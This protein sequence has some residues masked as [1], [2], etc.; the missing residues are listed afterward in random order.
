MENR[1]IYEN[2]LGKPD[3]ER[4]VISPDVQKESDALLRGAREQVASRDALKKQLDLEPAKKEAIFSKIAEALKAPR[5]IPI[6]KAAIVVAEYNSIVEE[7]E[8]FVKENVADPAFAGMDPTTLGHTFASES[9]FVLKK[10]V[11]DGLKPDGSMALTP[12]ETATQYLISYENGLITVDIG[13]RKVSGSTSEAAAKVAPSASAKVKAAAAAAG[14]KVIDKV[15][16]PDEAVTKAPE[17]KEVEE[18]ALKLMKSGGLAGLFVNFFVKI[19]PRGEDSTAGPD[20][21]KKQYAA[22]KFEVYKNVVKGEG[23]MEQLAHYVCGFLGAGFAKDKVDGMIGELGEDSSI[24]RILVDL[25][26]KVGKVGGKVAKVT[27]AGKEKAEQVAGGTLVANVFKSLGWGGTKKLDV[28]T[29]LKADEVPEEAVEMKIPSNGSVQF[30]KGVEVYKADG[31]LAMIDS[32]EKVEGGKDGVT[33]I[34]KPH[35]NLAKGSVFSKGVEFR[36]V[37]E[38]KE[39]ATV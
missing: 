20:E 9:I 26:S 1:L 30:K 22:R 33:L 28:A 2:P 11:G 34:L 14:K 6:G 31:K 23:A 39:E 12:G 29:V 27:G 10:T 17:E 25:R 38:P 35:Q 21:T 18:K 32:T 5:S 7:V 19:P 13:G 36:Q 24:K 15:K 8:K 16:N 4:S 3:P 37:E